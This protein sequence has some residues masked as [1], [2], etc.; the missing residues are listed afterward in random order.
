MFVIEDYTHC[1]LNNKFETF[2][3]ALAELRRRARVPWDQ[4]PNRAPC[5]KWRTCNRTYEVAEYDVSEK[6]RKLIRRVPVLKVSASG[7]EWA[8][9][10]RE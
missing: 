2:E 6:P 8:R 9:G 5:T 1:D 7:V 3:L 10:F 4:E